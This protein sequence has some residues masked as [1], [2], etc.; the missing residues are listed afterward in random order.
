[1]AARSA[2]SLTSVSSHGMPSQPSSL[3]GNTGLAHQI[4]FH[5]TAR[6]FTHRLVGKARRWG[7]GH[8]AGVLHGHPPRTKAVSSCSSLLL[9][10]CSP[11][12]TTLFLAVFGG[13]FKIEVAQSWRNKLEG[14]AD[15]LRPWI[16][17]LSDCAHRSPPL[18][19]D[20]R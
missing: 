4:T 3:G 11:Y 16:R 9:T 5:Q 7:V 20:G 10:P 18:R 8:V 17:R 2:A 13:K 12:S 19:L 14:A 6:N 1:M 15:L